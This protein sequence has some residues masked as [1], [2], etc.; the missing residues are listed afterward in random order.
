MYALQSISSVHTLGSKLFDRPSYVA[1]QWLSIDAE[2]D[3][4]E[5]SFSIK[6]WSELISS[7]LAFWFSEK[8][9]RKFAELGI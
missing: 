4:L 1:P 2:R 6:I 9:I 8:T 7:G 3:D 5:W